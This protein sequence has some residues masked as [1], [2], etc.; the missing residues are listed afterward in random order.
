MTIDDIHGW[1]DYSHLYREAI[2]R[3]PKNGTL[4]ELGVWCG[5]SLS[6]LALESQALGRE[7]IQIIGIDSWKLE[8]WDGYGPLAVKW[9]K[10]PKEVC[11]ENLKAL[12]I[13][14]RI[15]LIESDSVQAAEQFKDASVDFVWFDS[16]H[17]PCHVTGELIA[18]LPKIRRPAWCAGHDVES[19]GLFDAVREILPQ[20]RKVPGD[21]G[22]W[23]AEL[24]E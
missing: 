5:K 2:T 23:R 24:P 4:V 7:D 20:S 11:E 3:C 18:W 13:A 6:F 21:F 9:T 17:S 16:D 14:H 8:G 15:K 22:S 19:P 10:S 12:G 1:F